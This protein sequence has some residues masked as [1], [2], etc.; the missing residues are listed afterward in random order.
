MASRSIRATWRPFMNGRY[1]G[2]LAP[3]NKLPPAVGRTLFT[4]FVGA[5]PTLRAAAIADY[6]MSVAEGAAEPETILADDQDRNPSILGQAHGGSGFALGI[7]L[8]FNWLVLLLWALVRLESK[9][10]GFFVQE[11]VGVGGRS[12]RCYKFRSMH[13]GTK[14]A[15][16]A[17]GVPER[18][19]ADG[20]LHAA[21]Q[22][23]RAA[24]A[25]NIL[26]NDMSLAGRAL[27]AIAAGARGLEAPVGRAAHQARH[28]GAGAGQ[29]NRY[30]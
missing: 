17:R 29:W 1:S 21:H 30:E 13:V 4:A 22:A 2:R 15:W 19:H 27:S 3:L 5:E 26:C 9:G 10:P 23:R 8:F 18:H 6:V 12:F 25:W 20:Q 7:I 16:H 24:A 28:H 14:E 11:R